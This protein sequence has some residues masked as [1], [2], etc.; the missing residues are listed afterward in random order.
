MFSAPCAGAFYDALVFK[1]FCFY[2]G[3]RGLFGARFLLRTYV[4][5]VVQRHADVQCLIFNLHHVT[6]VTERREYGWFMIFNAMRSRV[7]GAEFI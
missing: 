3:E 5:V 7:E 2:K 6:M 1:I 4:H